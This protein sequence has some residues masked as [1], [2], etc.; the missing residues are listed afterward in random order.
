MNVPRPRRRRS[1]EAR[2]ADY[3][4][5]SAPANTSIRH[6]PISV[7]PSPATAQRISRTT[8][9]SRPVAED[10]G[11]VE[12]VAA[13]GRRNVPCSTNRR[14]RRRVLL[15][16]CWTTRCLGDLTISLRDMTA[17]R[18]R[19]ARAALPPPPRALRAN[20][21]EQ[22]NGPRRLSRAA[23]GTALYAAQVATRSVVCPPGGD[24]LG[25]R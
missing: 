14:A 16:A 5:T 15:A 20:C 13:R 23:E 12:R 19:L 21:T 22:S 18:C 17:A 7:R 1:A 3:P 10:L 11:R 9:R 4:S 8:T 6:S 24:V 25:K 2:A